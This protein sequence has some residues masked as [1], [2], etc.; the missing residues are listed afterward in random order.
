MIAKKG[1]FMVVLL[2]A[3]GL[4]LLSAASPSYAVEL[5]VQAVG[6]AQKAAAGNSEQAALVVAVT[7]GGN[8]VTALQREQF[9]IRQLSRPRLDDPII[10]ILCEPVVAFQ[11]LGE[12]A[13]L[14]R[15]LTENCFWASG[16]YTFQAR[17][18]GDDRQGQALAK[19]HIPVGPKGATPGQPPR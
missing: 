10:L 8:P 9:H 3:L 6:D 4:V 16:D 13:Y 15:I 14:I 2:F 11:E 1:L 5:N 19:I 12:G 7:E 17:V 18:I